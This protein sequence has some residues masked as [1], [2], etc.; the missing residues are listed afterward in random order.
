MVFEHK[1]IESEVEKLWAKNKKAI[2]KSIQN[3]KKKKLFSFLEG[4]PTANAPPGLHH[5][6]TRVFKDLFCRYKYMNGFSVPRKG[7]WD[8]H[9][10]PVEVQVEKKLGLSNKKDVIDYGK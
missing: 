6:E 7:G 1:K 2:E 8:C 5:L 10:L 3:D 4:P 9:G